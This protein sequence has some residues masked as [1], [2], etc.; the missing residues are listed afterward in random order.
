MGTQHRFHILQSGLQ[1]R[2]SVVD[3]ARNIPTGK[4]NRNQPSW[5]EKGGE[6]G[7]GKEPKSLVIP[8]RHQQQV[9]SWYLKKSWSKPMIQR[10]VGGHMNYPKQSVQGGE[11]GWGGRRAAS[12]PRGAHTELGDLRRTLQSSLS[13]LLT[14]NF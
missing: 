11:R 13:S 2:V 10:C 14:R 1:E 7:C 3:G 12:G 6:T 8:A 4:G 9:S 5:G